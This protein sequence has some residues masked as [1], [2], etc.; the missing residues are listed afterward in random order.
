MLEVHRSG[1]RYWRGRSQKVSVQ[2]LTL[3]AELKPWL[4]LSLGSA[5]QRT[6]VSLLTTAA[7]KVSRWLVSKL[8][9]QQG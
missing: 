4:G 5:G 6:L 3:M 7:V 1:Y 9:K 2:R 8:I